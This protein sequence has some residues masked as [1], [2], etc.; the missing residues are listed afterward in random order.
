MKGITAVFYRDYRQ[1]ITNVGFVFWDIFVPLTYLALFGMGFERALATALVVDGKLLEYTAFLFPGVIAMIAFTVAMDAV[2]VFHGQRVWDLLRAPDLSDYSTAAPDRQDLFQ[3]GIE[4]D[5]CR[6][7][8]QPRR[9][10][11]CT[12]AFAGTCC[13]SLRCCGHGDDRRLVF[14]L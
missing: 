6:S 1:R 9:F 8:R 11:A 10:R 4:P 14:F 13:L 5:R 2:G 12:S 3:C 7:G